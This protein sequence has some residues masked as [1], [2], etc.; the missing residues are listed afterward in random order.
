[1][2]GLLRTS[3]CL[4]IAIIVSTCASVA[5]ISADVILDVNG[6]PGNA[7]ITASVT[8]GDSFTAAG[9]SGVIDFFL[10][11]NKLKF[12]VTIEGPNGNIN[13]WFVR[14]P[15]DA[16]YFNLVRISSG[17]FSGFTL[18]QNNPITS[19]SNIV[20]GDITALAAYDGVSSLMTTFQGTGPNTIVTLN[21]NIVPEPASLLLL[22]LGGVLLT[23]RQR[24]A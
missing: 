15:A 12:F 20:S 14:G 3:W 24:V 1:M 9:S 7:T 16:S 19:S 23:R 22:G 4:G 11:P 10:L 2:T 13:P 6:T 8:N 21:Y 18:D 5:P 17:G